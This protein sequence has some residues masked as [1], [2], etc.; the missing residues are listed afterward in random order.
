MRQACI[1]CQNQTV[2]YVIHLYYIVHI[3]KIRV[4]F[5]WTQVETKK[6]QIQFVAALIV[7]IIYWIR[8]VFWDFEMEIFGNKMSQQRIDFSP[9]FCFFG[10][11]LLQTAHFISEELVHLWQWRHLVTCHRKIEFIVWWINQKRMC[12]LSK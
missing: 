6:I 4:Y 10:G 1:K 3:Y 11:F 9:Y 8:I 5:D 7:Y 12:V 2:C